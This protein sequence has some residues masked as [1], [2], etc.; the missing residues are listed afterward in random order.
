MNVLLLT[1]SLLLCGLVIWFVKTIYAVTREAEADELAQEHIL[2]EYK[3][4]F[5]KILE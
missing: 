5:D 4:L 1:L 2:Q 3:K